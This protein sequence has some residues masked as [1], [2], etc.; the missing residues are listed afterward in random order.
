MDLCCYNSTIFEPRHYLLGNYARTITIESLLEIC[1]YVRGTP[2]WA[3]LQA[4]G[5]VASLHYFCMDGDVRYTTGLNQTSGDKVFAI[6]SFVV[7][8]I[9]WKSVLNSM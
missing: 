6:P 8:V 5:C 1:R 3:Q 4:Y 7:V 9:Q 2:G